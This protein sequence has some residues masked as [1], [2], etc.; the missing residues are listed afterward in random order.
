MERQTTII[1]AQYADL[2]Q[3]RN[4]PFHSLPST[5]DKIP[6]I[7]F[8]HLKYSCESSMH[9]VCVGIYHLRLCKLLQNIDCR[10]FVSFT[11]FLVSFYMPTVLFLQVLH[12]VIFVESFTAEILRPVFIG[13]ASFF[14][15]HYIIEIIERPSLFSRFSCLLRH[16]FI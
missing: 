1:L 15:S 8:N 2:L 10:N 4:I 14:L 11:F 9:E 5:R 7:H 16:G 6:W 12:R 13:F 3:L